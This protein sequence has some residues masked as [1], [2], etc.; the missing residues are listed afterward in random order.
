MNYL[1]YPCKVMRITQNYNGTTSHL[2][3]STGKPKDYPWDEGCEDTGRNNCYCPCDKMKVK[4]IYGVGSGGTNAIWLES[5]TKVDFADGTNNYFT[6]MIIHPNDDDLKKIKVGQIFKRGEKICRE[7]NDGTSS[8]HFHFS[9]G[10]GKVS[11]NG[12]IRNNKGKYVLTTTDGTYKPEQLFFI[13][14]SFTKIENAKC[15]SF[16]KIPESYT[17]GNYKVTADFLYV[18]TGAG[19]KYKAKTFKQLTKNARAKILKLAKYEANGYVEGLTFSVTKIK[20]NWG[21]TPSGWVC[22]DYCKKI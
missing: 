2:P 3:C 14:E 17:V 21:K 5:T 4:R 9:A 1:T 20:D 18:R 8:Y 11:G 22:L 13:D 16:K 15:L 6:L 10:K 19:T 12:W 7:G